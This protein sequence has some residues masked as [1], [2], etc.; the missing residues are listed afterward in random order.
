MRFV[1]LATGEVFTGVLPIVVRLP[2]H[3]DRP[4]PH[5]RIQVVN[6]DDPGWDEA[7][8]RWMYL[9]GY[10]VVEDESA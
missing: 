1:S 7:L 5:T 4:V 6:K 3:K 9:N 10:A 2:I 8:I